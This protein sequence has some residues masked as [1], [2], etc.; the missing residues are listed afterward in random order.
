MNFLMQGLGTEAPLHGKTCWTLEYWVPPA[1]YMNPGSMKLGAGG[2]LHEATAVTGILMGNM[3]DFNNC[4]FWSKHLLLIESQTSLQPTQAATISK[5][6]DH[7]ERVCTSI[8]HQLVGIREQYRT[9]P[10]CC[11]A[12]VLQHH[13][14]WWLVVFQLSQL[15]GLLAFLIYI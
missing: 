2:L 13:Q 15:S 11:K 1:L 14:N 6:L 12:A 7:P 5:M 3:I 9:V 4:G 10:K 8:N